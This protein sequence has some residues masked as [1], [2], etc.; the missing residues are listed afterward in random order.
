VSYYQ[1][2]FQAAV[3]RQPKRLAIIRVNPE[4]SSAPRKAVD[5]L[6]AGGLIVFPTEEGYLVGCDALDPA[7]VQRL[8]E[9]TGAGSEH[10]VR[11]A[12]TREQGARLTGLARPLAHPVPLALMRAADLPMAA[13]AVPPGALPPPTAQHAIFI[14]GDGVDLVLDAGPVRRQP[15]AGRR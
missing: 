14:V 4:D 7:A 15:V 5:V 9:V 12:A 6:R 8:C 10:L 11:F 1:L 13:T 2:T 3:G